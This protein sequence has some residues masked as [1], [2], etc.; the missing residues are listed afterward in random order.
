M[1]ILDVGTREVLRE[2]G[3]DDVCWDGVVEQAVPSPVES[4]A[5]ISDEAKGLLAPCIDMAIP[6][7]EV[8]RTRHPTLRS[9]IHRS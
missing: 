1:V 7:L 9:R 6:I 4:S 2:V 3:K 8:V 5:D